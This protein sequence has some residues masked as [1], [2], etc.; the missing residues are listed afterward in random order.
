MKGGANG[1]IMFVLMSFAMTA[2]GVAIIWRVDWLKRNVL[3][4]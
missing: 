1:L 4:A 3:G 2:V